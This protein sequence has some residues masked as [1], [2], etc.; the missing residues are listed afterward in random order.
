M[1]KALQIKHAPHSSYEAKLVKLAD[2]LYN[3]RDLEKT[4]PI[5]WTESRILEYFK[6]SKEVVAGLRGTNE[7]MEK[8]LDEI[9]KKWV[10]E[11]NVC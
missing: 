7:Q 9:Y 5:G 2:K 11:E 3:L 8:S 10:P 6:W 1:R 4:P